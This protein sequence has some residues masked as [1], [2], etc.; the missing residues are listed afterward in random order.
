MVLPLLSGP[1]PQTMPL[2][3]YDPAIFGYGSPRANP[4]LEDTKSRPDTT[5][6]YTG[7]MRWLALIIAALVVLEIVR[8]TFS[9]F[10]CAVEL[11]YNPIILQSDVNIT[12]ECYRRHIIFPFGF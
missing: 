2:R 9:F 6:G 12:E 4:Y 8:R 7:T 11:R 5:E 3:N 10:T 1:S